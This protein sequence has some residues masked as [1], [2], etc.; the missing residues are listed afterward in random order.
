MAKANVNT[1]ARFDTAF[2]ILFLLFFRKAVELV[3]SAWQRIAS[4]ALAPDL[5]REPL[6]TGVV[7]LAIILLLLLVQRKVMSRIVG[8]GTY[9]VARAAI[10][11]VIGALVLFPCGFPVMLGLVLLDHFLLPDI[12]WVG[13][14]IIVVTL[15]ISSGVAGF[16]SG[17]RFGKWDFFWGIVTVL[18]IGAVFGQKVFV[19]FVSFGGVLLV[20]GSLTGALLG[21]R[22]GVARFQRGAK[23]TEPDAEPAAS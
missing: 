10:M 14:L 20:A 2:L 21:A 18:F 8:A 3:G 23:E 6:A 5:P 22:L 13:G 7:L 16:W 1:N 11:A 15:S 4:G 9:E 19:E 12:P 17:W